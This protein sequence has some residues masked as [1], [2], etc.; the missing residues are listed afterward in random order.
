[1]AGD[2]WPNS[3]WI[4]RLSNI[5]VT[6]RPASEVYEEKVSQGRQSDQNNSEQGGGGQPATRCMSNFGESLRTQSIKLTFKVP[7][8]LSDESDGDQDCRSAGEGHDG[9]RDACRE[10]PVVGRGIPPQALAGRRVGR[11]GFGGAAAFAGGGGISESGGLPSGPPACA[12][13][14]RRRMRSL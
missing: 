4:L 7:D 9:R 2:S 10:N 14:R 13:G 3:V 8:K 5:E 6:S 1:M 12:G 11:G